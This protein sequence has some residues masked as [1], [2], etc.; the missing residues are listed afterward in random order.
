MIKTD[1][2]QVWMKELEDGSRAIGIFNVSE[3]D[4]VIRFYWNN[5]ALNEHYKVRDLWRQKD[6]GNYGTMFSTKVAAHGVT[7]IRITQ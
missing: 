7:L 1:T 4:D 3:K 5:L 2:Y 6:L